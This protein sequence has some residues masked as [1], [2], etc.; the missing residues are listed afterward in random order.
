MAHQR[1]DIS[2]NY[3]PNVLKDIVAVQWAR[4]KIIKLN[5][6]NTTS[7]EPVSWLD[8]PHLE[9]I[10]LIVRVINIKKPFT[11]AMF[12]QL[13]S[14][15]VGCDSIGRVDLSRVYFAH[16]Q[17]LNIDFEVIELFDHKAMEGL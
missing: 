11:K 8:C 14:I 2:E 5:L 12:A 6:P 4:L 3:Y 1:I 7:I 16:Q 9:K 15:K 10:E 17:P 13:S